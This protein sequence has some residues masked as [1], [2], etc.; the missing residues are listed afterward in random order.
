MTFSFVFLLFSPSLT[1]K[2]CEERRR[3]EFNPLTK[4]IKKKGA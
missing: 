1:T 4:A 2:I 3:G